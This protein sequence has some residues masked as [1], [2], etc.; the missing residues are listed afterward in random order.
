MKLKGNV[1]GVGAVNERADSFNAYN[2]PPPVVENSA[3][4]QI[5]LR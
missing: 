5:S 4:D 2:E 1:S 3:I